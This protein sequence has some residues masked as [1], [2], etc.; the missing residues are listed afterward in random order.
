[1]KLFFGALG[2]V[3]M[4]YL[5][6]LSFSDTLGLTDYFPKV[7]SQSNMWPAQVLTVIVF[8]LFYLLGRSKTPSEHEDESAMQNSAMEDESKR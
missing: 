3:L 4:A 8:G 7:L 6:L 5:G 1:M 2:L